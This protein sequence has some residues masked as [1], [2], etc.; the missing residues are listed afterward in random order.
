MKFDRACDTLVL[1]GQNGAIRSKILGTDSVTYAFK[2]QDTYI[3]AEVNQKTMT[4]VYL[5]PVFRYSGT[6]ERTAP[7]IDSAKTW[8]FR[9]VCLICISILTFL[10]I[11]HKRKK[12]F[13][14]S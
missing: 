5:N 6:I 9:F 7:E 8:A 14:A 10:F 12:A 2:E 11:R 13:R 4:N 3:R 1:Y